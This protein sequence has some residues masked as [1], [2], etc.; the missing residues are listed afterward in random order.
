MALRRA[1]L[2]L[3]GARAPYCARVVDKRRARAHR[4][5]QRGLE[6]NDDEHN[7]DDEDDDD[8]DTVTM[9]ATTTTMTMTRM[10]TTMTM[11]IM[12]MVI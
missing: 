6:R 10:M 9:S 11:T 7:D 12:L 2:P 5:T 1:R 8:D 4:R 3:A